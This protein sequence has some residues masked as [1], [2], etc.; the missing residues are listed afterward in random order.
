M[1]INLARR[2]L[3]LFNLNPV[4]TM[5]K[6]KLTRKT[7]HLLKQAIHPDAAGIDIGAEEIVVAIPLDRDDDRPVRTY[8]SFTADLKSLR[9][10]LIEHRIQTVAMESTGVYWIPLY[11]LLE[12]SSIEVCLVN[13]RH[14]KGVPGKK[15][16]VCDAQW[17]QQLHTAGLLKSSF[18]PRVEIDKV[19]QLMR[20]RANLI[21]ESARHIQHMQK[22]LT[23]MNLQI[24][25]VFSDLDG[26]SAMLIIE[27]ILSDNRNVDELWELRDSRS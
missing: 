18:R 13:A 24:H 8:E 22:A 23:E 9:D 11:D 25:H 19:R 15:T 14:V 26:K 27:S 21:R 2:R 7:K 6:G 1:R 10:W 5:S 12:S 20:H 17:L 3:R 4:D 16:D